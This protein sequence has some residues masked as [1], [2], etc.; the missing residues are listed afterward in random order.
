M[1]REE[2]PG[3]YRIEVPLPGN[4]LK[5][6]NA[7]LIRG[8]GRDLLVDNGFNMRASEEALRSALDELHVDYACLDFF[9]THLHSDHNGLTSRLQSSTSRIYCGRIDGE[10][11][12]A[13][14]RDASLWTTMMLE[15]RHHGFPQA[16]L[17]ELVASHPGKVYAN[18]EPLEFSFVE[19][20]DLLSCGPYSFRVLSVP[21]H[22]PGHMALYEE[23]R[24]FL[25]AG[26]H[27]LGSITPNI[28]S[29]DGV[30]DSLGDYLAS[31]AKVAALPVRLC[32][33]GHRAVVADTQERIL[34][35][36]AHHAQRLGEALDIVTA[37][38]RARAWE[39][40]SRMKWGLRGVWREFRVQQQCFA[41]GEAVAHLDHLAALGRLERIVEDDGGVS[42]AP[43]SR[44]CA[45]RRAAVG[46]AVHGNE[47]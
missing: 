1:Y 33:P 2:L 35:L 24:N 17:E 16:A 7:Y 34:A 40:A 22:T 12:N 18:E 5:S 42:F 46:Q 45:V 25:L 23:T 29:W 38:G 10:K 31:L 11:I 36:H 3:L 8:A 41:V 19:E 47:K 32:F 13:F 6:L 20:G 44:H 4:P 43:A 26:D 21:G 28:T 30:P 37:L 27:I 14:I 15:L 39:V 9:I